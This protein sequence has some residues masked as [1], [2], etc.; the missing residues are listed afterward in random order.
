MD[1]DDALF[2]DAVAS[3]ST[4]AQLQA[5]LID[6]ILDVS[7]I[8]SGKLRLAPEA[9]EVSRLIMS[10]VDSVSAT[11]DAKEISITT[12]LAPA[13]GTALIDATRVQQVIWNLLSNALKFTPRH[14]AVTVAARRTTSQ[15]QISVTDNG[16]GIDPQFLSHVFEPFRQAETPS[17]RTHGGLGLGLSIVRYIAEAHGGSITA[18]SEGRG[19][20]ATFTLMLPI[21]AVAARSSSPARPAPGF[22]QPDRL[23]GIDIVLVDDDADSRK[24]IAAVLTAAGARLRAFDSARGALQAIDDRQPQL[25]LT[26]I[27]MPDVDGYALTRMLRARP[28][29]RQMKVVA[30]SA[31]P[32]FLDQQTD[33][34]A[35]LSKPIDPFELVEQIAKVATS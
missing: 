13:L 18:Q 25:V 19:K 4:N 15:L 8:V 22:P 24:V 35:Y 34:D 17:T 33:F 21:R 23:R 32:A 14:G 6:D 28:D 10:A 26:D 5:R 2:Q 31:F 3:I 11:A 27:A 1:P 9:V 30:L 29:G 20:G 12:A 16:E 7:R